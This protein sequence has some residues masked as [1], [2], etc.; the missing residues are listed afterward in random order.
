LSFVFNVWFR[1]HVQGD[2][3]SI[4]AK[5]F[6][7][8]ARRGQLV[9]ISARTVATAFVGDV[10]RV[11]QPQCVHCRHTLGTCTLNKKNNYRLWLFQHGR[12]RSEYVGSTLLEAKQKLAAILMQD[13]PPG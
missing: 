13:P 3:R 5:F 4:A 7:K 8:P 6:S 1:V 2:A 11:V 9:R 10:F 12:I